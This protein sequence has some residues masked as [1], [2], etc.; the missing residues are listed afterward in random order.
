MKCIFWV[1][2]LNVEIIVSMLAY[3]SEAGM[4]N[5]ARI[6]LPLKYS[7]SFNTDGTCNDC[8]QCL[9]VIFNVLDESMNFKYFESVLHNYKFL[10]LLEC[11]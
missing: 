7:Q 8:E 3:T 2:C 6:L 4:V 11:P 1:I 5:P 9:G 10:Y